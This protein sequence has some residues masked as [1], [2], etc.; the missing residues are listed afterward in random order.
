MTE[1]PGARLR[2]TPVQTFLLFP[3]ALLAWDGVRRLPR[4]R[5]RYLPLV[6]WGYLQ[7]RLGGA[8]RNQVGGGGPGIDQPPERLVT[9]GPYTLTRNPMYLGHVIYMLGVVLAL[10]SRAGAIAFLLR[11]LWFHRRVLGDEQRLARL[12]GP[13]YERYRARVKRWVPGLF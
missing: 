2:S 9:T 7:Y 10:G 11:A 4:L 1:R 3:L 5:K 8:Y 13:D 6:L 12:F